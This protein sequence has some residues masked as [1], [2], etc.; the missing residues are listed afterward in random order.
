MPDCPQFCFLDRLYRFLFDNFAFLR[1]GLFLHPFFYENCFAKQVSR[2][3]WMFLKI[4]LFQPRVSNAGAFSKRNQQKKI[5]RYSRLCEVRWVYHTKKQIMSNNGVWSRTT[6]VPC[7]TG[8]FFMF[9][10]DKFCLCDLSN[11]PKSRNYIEMTWFY[12]QSVILYGR[13]GRDWWTYGLLF[14]R[15]KG[16]SSCQI[17]RK[18]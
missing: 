8:S 5:F 11:V 7:R 3:Q 16:K 4:N 14:V 9:K 15:K 1:S 2:E 6:V 13:D 17:K 18:F 10:Y 12:A